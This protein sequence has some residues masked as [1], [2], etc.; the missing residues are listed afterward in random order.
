[1]HIYYASTIAN[2][3]ATELTPYCDIIHIAGSIRRKKEQVKDIEIV[4]IPKKITMGERNL[5]GEEINK[6]I[7]IHPEFERI[8]KS[9]GVIEKGKFTGRYMKLGIQRVIDSVSYSI[10][11][12][13]FMPQQHDYY[14]QLAIRTG[15]AEYSKRF[16]AG[17]WY[18]K[19]WCGCEGELRLQS[20][21]YKDKADVWHL[22][23]TVTDP[24]L[25][26]VWKSE[27]EFFQW[28]GIQWLEPEHRNL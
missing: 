8:I 10:S 26:P 17:K 5:F 19:G 15:S 23:P 9:H 28:L 20:Q 1:M 21:C 18:A 3:I 14:R 6:R 16:I 12:D 27:E 2:M 13:L 25:P 4:C 11:L 7:V 22:R 24:K